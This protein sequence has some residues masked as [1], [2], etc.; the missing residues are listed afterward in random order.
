MHNFA[1]ELVKNDH[2]PLDPAKYAIINV[3]VTAT[4]TATPTA[5]SSAIARGY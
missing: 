2:T 5:T 1:V 3:T 4:A